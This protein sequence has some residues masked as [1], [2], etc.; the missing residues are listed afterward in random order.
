MR[1]A[2]AAEESINWSKSGRTTEFKSIITILDASKVKAITQDIINAKP[3]FDWPTIPKSLL[4]TLETAIILD[5][6]VA[7]NS[8]FELGDK[9]ESRVHHDYRSG[10]RFEAWL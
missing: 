5:L 10:Y 1:R 3:E 9:V 6:T 8:I 7:G 4:D 2:N